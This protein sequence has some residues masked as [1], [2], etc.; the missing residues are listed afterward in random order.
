MLKA[1]VSFCHVNACRVNPDDDSQQVEEL[2]QQ[3]Q[4]RDDKISGLET[5]IAN[6]MQNGVQNSVVLRELHDALAAKSA[7]IVE[8]QDYIDAQA[9][10]EV[11]SPNQI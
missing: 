11:G 6:I 4:S 9:A 2:Q 5:Y 1:K 8:L 3:L 7:T 10:A